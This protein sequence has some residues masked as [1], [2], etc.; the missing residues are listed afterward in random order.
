MTRMQAFQ[1]VS[2]ER[3][4]QRGQKGYGAAEDAA[5]SPIQWLAIIMHEVGCLATA[6]LLPYYEK[7]SQCA[8]RAALIKIAA[9]AVAA[10]ESEG[11][12]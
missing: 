11:W 7:S 5:H 9:V 12:K 8:V 1:L 2:K 4:R 3:A 10:L 6:V